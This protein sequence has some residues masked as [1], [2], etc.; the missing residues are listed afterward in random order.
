MMKTVFERIARFQKDRRG[1]AAMIVALVAVPMMGTLGF[2]VDYGIALA[3][4]SKL[5][6]A[7]DA[8]AIV[9]IN[10]AQSVLSAGGSTA[11][12]ISQA[13]TA[14]SAA[15]RA[16]A[17]SL[18]FASVPTP[19]I[20]IPA[21]VGLTVTA[22]VKYSTVSSTAFSKILGMPALTLAGT[23]GSTLT[24]P[25]YRNYYVILDIS[26]SMGIG[27]TQADMTTLYNRS[28]ALNM[29]G[30]GCVF[31]CHDTSPG[32][33]HSMEY[34][35][36]DSSYGTPVTLRIDAALSAVQSMISTAQTAQANSVATG[37]SSSLINIG[38]YTMSG[39]AAF[40]ST[41]T[42]MSSPPSA[43]SNMLNVISAPTSNFTNLALMA[44]SPASKPLT[45]TSPVIGLGANNGSVGYGDSYPANSLDQFRTSVF[46][47]VSNGTGASAAQPQNFVF[48]VT[49]GV[50]DKYSPICGFTHCTTPFDSAY[51]DALKSKAT[52]GVIYTTY[53]Q[54]YQNND[55]AQGLDFRYSGLIAPIASRI[56]P[57]LQACA[58]SSLYYFEAADGPAIT[59]GMQ[60]LMANSALAARL[61]Q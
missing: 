54:I 13:Q 34:V 55:P 42:T 43:Q 25:T 10:T 21:P 33:A 2:A 17:G 19:T 41:S 59:A 15:F 12:A 39:Y 11:T 9:A 51:C 20:T 24:M 50:S 49:D 45:S 60:Q 32:E 53:N 14:A 31:A 58:T 5:D 26:Q 57:A 23:S 27:A 46:S 4:K 22:T 48:I 56:A 29:Q 61:S 52:V 35:A 47:T 38:L 36:H 28:K 6:N 40:G 44:A 3:D 16:N 1:N 30:G 7:S 8:A 18:A 37:G